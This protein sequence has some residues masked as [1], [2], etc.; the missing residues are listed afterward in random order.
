MTEFVYNN[1][2]NFNISYISF[3]FN[4]K[5][6]LFIPFKKKTNLS[7]KFHLIDKFVKTR[8]SW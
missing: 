5:Y 8:K 7:L 3:K 6:N 4:Y 1:N 2:K